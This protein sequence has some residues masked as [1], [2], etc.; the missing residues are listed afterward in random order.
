MAPPGS[1]RLRGSKQVA[2]QRYE[3]PRAFEALANEAGGRR[4]QASPSGQ[5]GAVAARH[6]LMSSSQAVPPSRPVSCFDCPLTSLTS[7]MRVLSG[8]SAR[9]WIGRFS[10]SS[11]LENN[12]RR[13]RGFLVA[14]ILSMAALLALA[15]PALAMKPAFFD[16]LNLK[17][18][19]QT[20]AA[21]GPCHWEAGDAWAE[22]RNVTIEQGS[23]VASSGN[24]S[25]IV[26]K[27]KD[28]D[29]WLD[30]SSSSQFT[31][32]PAEA[33]A[34]AIVHRTD[35]TTYEYPWYDDVQLQ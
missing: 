31:S 29:W 30:A 20:V 23:V 32:G 3:L 2:R 34:V 18:G 6:E 12:M 33:Y 4:G 22:I 14:L 13:G 9:G 24:A 5:P 7:D 11:G 35:G 19:R 8:R 21:G 15:T 27:G 26:R 25:T 10:S 17:D 1:P 16:D 28:R